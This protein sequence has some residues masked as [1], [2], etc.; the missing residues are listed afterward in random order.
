MDKIKKILD[1]FSFIEKCI[2][3]GSFLLITILFFIFDSSNILSYIS[4]IV[5][6][7]ALIFMAKANPIAHALFIIFS[8]LYAY[9]SFKNNYYG[10]VFD[11]IVLTIPLSVISLISWFKNLNTKNS[12]ETK[13]SSIN[14]KQTIFIAFISISVSVIMYFIL[15][16]LGTSN[17]IASTFSVATNFFAA[18]LTIKR[19]HYFAL[20]YAFNDIA[21]VILWSLQLSND[22]SYITIVVYFVITLINDIYIFIS[23]IRIRDKQKSSSV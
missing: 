13:I 20:A 18:S 4:S 17:L 9:M 16:Y 3:L 6:I 23:W 15:Q 22:I 11:Y 7:T 14:I 1:Y 2:W 10:E 12:L 21:L 19:S 8:I 5:G